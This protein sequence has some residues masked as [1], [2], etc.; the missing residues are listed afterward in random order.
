MYEIYLD[1]QVNFTKY[2]VIY[3]NKYL[4]LLLTFKIRNLG[5]GMIR[6]N[7]PEFYATQRNLDFSA[8]NTA[9]LVVLEFSKLLPKF[10]PFIMFI[11]F[12]T[13]HV[14]ADNQCSK[15]VAYGV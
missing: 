7:A 10:K 5:F 12:F 14:A 3:Q 1:L 8:I 2:L 11:I 6:Q 9:Y 13:E 15:F 4:A